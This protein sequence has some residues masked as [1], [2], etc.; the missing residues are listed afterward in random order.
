MGH[1]SVKGILKAMLL[2]MGLS[3]LLLFSQDQQRYE[4][5]YILR[6]SLTGKA[7]YQYTISKGDTLKDGP[8]EFR[9]NAFDTPKQQHL[10]GIQLKG[11]FLKGLKTGSWRYRKVRFRLGASPTI[12]DNQISFQGSGPAYRVNGHF[13]SGRATGSWEVLK[14]KV[15]KGKP[16][17][18][19][20]HVKTGFTDGTIQDQLAAKGALDTMAGAV[21]EHGF[22]DGRWLFVQAGK[23]EPILEERIYR[24]GILR[25]HRLLVANDTLSLTHAGTY[26]DT[27]MANHHWDTLSAARAYQD[28]LEVTYASLPNSHPLISTRTRLG[29]EASRSNAFLSRCLSG[30]AL[31]D[32]Q[33]IWQL[34]SGS[35]RLQ[36]PKVKV[37]KNPLSAREQELYEAI[38]ALHDSTWKNLQAFFRD[39]QVSISKYAKEDI[40]F[41]YELLARHKEHIEHLTPFIK[42]IRNPAFTYV[43]RQKLIRNQ[44]PAFRYPDTLAFEFDGE[45]VKRVPQYPEDLEK[46]Q[47]ATA[48]KAHLEQVQQHMD[49]ALARVSQALKTIKKQERLAGKEEQLIQIRDSVL[50]LFD[51]ERKGL[52]QN[53]YHQQVSD[54]VRQ[55]Y[56]QLFRDYADLSLDLKIQQVSD[57]IACFQ[58]GFELYTALTRLPD[59][60][61]D[62]KDR[63][64]RSVWNP[65]TFTYMDERLKKPIYQAYRQKLLPTVLRDLQKNLNCGSIKAKAGNFRKLYRKLVQLRKSQTSMLEDQLAKSRSVGEVTD[66]MQLDLNLD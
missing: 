33:Q 63:Y 27:A 10:V 35:D 13:D 66:Q 28:F 3:P 11:Q 25:K 16:V 21:N 15:D 37:Q 61:R 42:Q 46:P 64:T 4:G 5:P 30:L 57:V 44:V 1:F 22:L 26:P 18:T 7:A 43:N 58:E 36:L 41:Y 23:D 34:V 31:Y 17:D 45:L 53:Q 39:A 29:F 40:K 54:S 32:D 52:Q 55:F 51:P 19:T 48:I 62:L 56:D 50:T 49:T 14:R 59:Q 60:R 24:D 47:S 20:L 9:K 65:H 6:D 8:F 2:Y 12:Q 38:G